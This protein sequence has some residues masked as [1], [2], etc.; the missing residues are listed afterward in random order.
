MGLV[1]STGLVL[2]MLNI[3]YDI[4][5]VGAI[6]YSREVFENLKERIEYVL[7]RESDARG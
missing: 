5:N 4:C 3:G 2:N 1:K 7:Y 6:S